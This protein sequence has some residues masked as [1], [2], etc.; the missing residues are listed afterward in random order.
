[1]EAFFY[2]TNTGEME[3]FLSHG[4][5][6]ATMLDRQVY[7]CVHSPP[8]GPDPK[9]PESLAKEIGGSGLETTNAE[10]WGWFT[11]AVAWS[12]IHCCGPLRAEGQ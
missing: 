5:K 9:N 12:R 6:S 4:H 8:V 2:D 3:A 11:T 1:V 7:C 10:N